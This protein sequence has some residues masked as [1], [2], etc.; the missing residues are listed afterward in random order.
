[1]LAS[2]TPTAARGG[3]LAAVPR[4]SGPQRQ[5]AAAASQARVATQKQALSGRNGIS[6]RRAR[7]AA[8]RRLTAATVA[9]AGGDVL[10]VGSSGQTAARVVVS[11]LRTGFKV[12]AGAGRGGGA[13]GPLQHSRTL[14]IPQI[15]RRFSAVGHWPRL[16]QFHLLH[17]LDFLLLNLGLLQAWTPTW[18]RARRWSSLPSRLRS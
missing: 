3:S 12:T 7:A 16:G 9:K 13:G 17:W 2:V 18:R 10:V 1:M 15:H 5:Q 8:A 4:L 11:L 14:C 6:Q